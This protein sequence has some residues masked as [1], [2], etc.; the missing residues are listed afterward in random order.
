MDEDKDDLN[1]DSDYS[2]DD[3]S[4]EEEVK[5]IKDP[6]IPKK[7]KGDENMNPRAKRVR[8]IICDD[9]DD[10]IKCFQNPP[11]TRP[12]STRQR[13]KTNFYNPKDFDDIEIP[14]DE[15]KVEYSIPDRA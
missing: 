3:E 6:K 2:G 15:G 12:R 11:P 13:N 14:R 1:F 8:T 5:V 4:E 9:S 10:D 7:R